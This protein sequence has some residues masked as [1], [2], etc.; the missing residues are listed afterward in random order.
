M[1][2]NDQIRIAEKI[3]L[4]TVSKMAASRDEYMAFFRKM[5]KKYGVDSPADLDD[6]KKK[7]FFDEVD[8]GWKAEEETD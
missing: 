2:I 6:A 8:K 4:E 5:L 3:A 7:Q 1:D